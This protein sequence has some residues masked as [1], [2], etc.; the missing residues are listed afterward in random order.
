MYTFTNLTEFPELPKKNKCFTFLKNMCSITRKDMFFVTFENCKFQKLNLESYG[1]YECSIDN[2]QIVEPLIINCNF[3]IIKNSNI[4][5]SE[6][7]KVKRLSIQC[8]EYTFDSKIEVISFI[9]K[10]SII[11]GINNINF[12]YCSV[13][14][15]HNEKLLDMIIN[16]DLFK[17]KHTH[18]DLCVSSRYKDKMYNFIYNY[19]DYNI[20]GG[21]GGIYFDVLRD[22]FKKI[23]LIKAVEALQKKLKNGTH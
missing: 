18:Y 3:L 8:L 5:L 14:L 4:K 7:I 23:K 22:R 1:I 17:D 12:R 21:C 16:G 2:C 9:I 15:D 6:H 19:A 10:D 13:H 11:K 20:F